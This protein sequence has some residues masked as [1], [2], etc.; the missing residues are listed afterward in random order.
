MLQKLV[1]VCLTFLS[2]SLSQNSEAM[3]LRRKFTSFSETKTSKANSTAESAPVL[4]AATN[5]GWLSQAVMPRDPAHADT[6]ESLAF[7]LVDWHQNPDNKSHYR[8]TRTREF[9]GYRVPTEAEW[10]AYD[11]D[12]FKRLELFVDQHGVDSFFDIF[13]R[14]CFGMKEYLPNGYWITEKTFKSLQNIAKKFAMFSN[15]Q[16]TLGRMYSF[17]TTRETMHGEVRDF[18]GFQ[19]WGSG[20]KPADR[21][22]TKKLTW[23]LPRRLDS[24]NFRTLE[25]ELE[26]RCK[27]IKSFLYPGYFFSSDLQAGFAPRLEEM[28]EE[29]T[30]HLSDIQLIELMTYFTGNISTPDLEREFQIRTSPAWAKLP[31]AVKVPEIASTEAFPNREDWTK[32]PLVMSALEAFRKASHE[33][34]FHP[35]ELEA[36]IWTMRLHG[37]N[38]QAYGSH[39]QNDLTGLLDPKT[40]GNGQTPARESWV[41][42]ES[43]RRREEVIQNSKPVRYRAKPGEP[44]LSRTEFRKLAKEGIERAIPPMQMYNVDVIGI[45]SYILA[46]ESKLFPVGF[47]A[48]YFEESRLRDWLQI[49]IFDP[50]KWKVL[51]DVENHLLDFPFARLSPPEDIKAEDFFKGYPEGESPADELLRLN[52]FRDI[53]VDLS[54]CNAELT[55]RFTFYDN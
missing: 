52:K 27:R 49:E 51:L 4:S 37:L 53:V 8:P 5:G 36:L 22:E 12:L 50:V 25:M 28:L 41:D 7:E 1:S 39:A 43:A 55:T 54:D 32:I 18:T 48:I 13:E 42:L 21:L 14:F 20:L 17:I 10:V 40:W 33:H 30:P 24:K 47:K 11:A 26:D 31:P 34:A 9:E 38:S 35:N 3:S 46:A 19:N 44:T 23:L 29:A 15:E 45:D 2:I 16:K 6:E